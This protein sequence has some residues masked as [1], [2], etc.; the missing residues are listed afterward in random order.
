MTPTFQ[1]SL[2]T[3]HSSYLYHII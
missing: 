3:V 1:L 2:D